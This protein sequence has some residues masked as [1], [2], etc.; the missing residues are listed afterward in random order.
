ML[1]TWADS[2]LA[3]QRVVH[4]DNVETLGTFLDKKFCTTPSC[5][6]FAAVFDTGLGDGL[7]V[8]VW[9]L[10]TT[11]MAEERIPATSGH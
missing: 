11:Y 4:T 5:T 2:S 6:H 8:L 10:V 3:R 1:K 9:I 7:Q